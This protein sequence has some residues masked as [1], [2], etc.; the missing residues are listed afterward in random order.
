MIQTSI[1]NDKGEIEQLDHHDARYWEGPYVYQPFP[2]TL[3]RATAG[4]GYQHPEQIIVK[5]Q[6]EWDR[7]GSDW[8]ETPDDA[9]TQRDRSDAEIARVAAERNASDLRM[10]DKAQRE[11]LAIDRATDELLPAIP[12][13][14]RQSRPKKT[15]I[16][17]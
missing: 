14:H 17:N 12:E 3:F 11:A 4:E 6:H 10:S 15:D 13:Q 1:R 7:L 8:K 9:R 2:K 16:Q 5:S